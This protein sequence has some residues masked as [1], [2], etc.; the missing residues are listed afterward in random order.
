MPITSSSSSNGRVYGHR[1]AFHA[2]GSP[3]P[4]SSSSSSPLSSG[5][6]SSS[7][8][9]AEAKG[10]I[11][12]TAKR[13]EDIDRDFALALKFQEDEKE[14]VYRQQQQQ[15]QQQRSAIPHQRH[16]SG[17]MFSQSRQ[18][19]NQQRRQQQREQ[20][21]GFMGLGFMDSSKC[22]GGSAYGG[23]GWPLLAGQI[24]TFNGIRF[25][26]GCFKC[27][28]CQQPISGQFQLHAPPSASGI[29]STSFHHFVP[30]SPPR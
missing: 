19:P 27:A 30:R 8:R 17:S 25:H 7:F 16:G 9:K 18:T 10:N 14:A 21:S 15:Q 3:P 5:V 23:C 12:N 13:Q 6:S 24:Q 22:G 1:G 26:A 29:A 28:H 20:Q 4:P 2:M 11:N